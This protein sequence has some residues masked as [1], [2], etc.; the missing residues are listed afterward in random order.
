MP[1]HKISVVI[2]GISPERVAVTRSRDE[3]RAQL[4]IRSSAPVVAVGTRA[5]D[6]FAIHQKDFRGLFA[7]M[8]IVRERFPVATLLLIGPTREELA[9]NDIAP[10]AWARVTGFVDRPAD[11]MAAADVVAIPSVSEGNSNV[12]C[13]AL[14]LGL[15][16]ATT[17]T[18]GHVPIVAEGG[19]SVV[20]TRQPG[21][22]ADA[23]IQLIE[24][25]PS[26]EKVKAVARRRLGIDRMIRSTVEAYE[27]ALGTERTSSRWRRA[28]TRSAG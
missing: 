6:R 23:I 18:G 25:P 19:G 21:A 7:A 5:N 10:P 28:P 22:L 27:Q 20:P 1:A 16:V 11:Y 26:Q 15:P 8:A 17:M 12:A 24:D 4:G 13:E 14:M 9:S 2:N 3:V